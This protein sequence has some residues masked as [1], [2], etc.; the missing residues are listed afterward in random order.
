M[1]WCESVLACII[2]LAVSPCYGVS[3]CYGVN[4]VIVLTV[5]WCLSAL[6]LTRDGWWHGSNGRRTKSS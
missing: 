2:V 4:F 5:F 6:V 1:L 3:L